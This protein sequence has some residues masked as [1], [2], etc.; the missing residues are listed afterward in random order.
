M[1]PCAAQWQNRQLPA[2]SAR[3][4]ERVSNRKPEGH[5]FGIGAAMRD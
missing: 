1:N 2:L 5:T 4:D 3:M